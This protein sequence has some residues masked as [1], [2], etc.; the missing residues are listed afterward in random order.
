MYNLLN[1]YI[2]F[3]K[4]YSLPYDYYVSGVRVCIVGILAINGL[5]LDSQWYQWITLFVVPCNSVLTPLLLSGSAFIYSQ[6]GR[7]VSTWVKTVSQGE[8]ESVLSASIF[9]LTQH[10][11]A[12]TACYC[13]RNTTLKF[14]L[15]IVKAHRH[16][17]F[18]RCLPLKIVYTHQSTK[19]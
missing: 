19:H 16:L 11:V 5:S 3:S 1:W 4:E 15:I 12:F 9:V 2:A 6:R 18:S 7:Q 13:L 10:S 17:I 14:Q 8:H